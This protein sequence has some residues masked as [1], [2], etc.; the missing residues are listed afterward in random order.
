MNY[1]LG[2]VINPDKDKV[3][4][5]RKDRPVWQQNLLNGIGGKIE[6]DESST[7]A[8]KREFI[9]ETGLKDEIFWRQFGQ[10]KGI[11]EV[12]SRPWKVHLFY[13]IHDYKLEN[14]DYTVMLGNNEYVEEHPIDSLPD[15][16]ISNLKWMIPMALYDTEYYKVEQV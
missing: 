5:I 12:D 15:D 16:V 8:M 13:A 10:L 11:S 4:L 7:E 14:L 9:E 1:V 3:L 6:K 2:F